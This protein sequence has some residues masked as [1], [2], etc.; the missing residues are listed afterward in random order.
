LS[1]QPESRKFAE[2]GASGDALDAFPVGWLTKPSSGAV[3][4]LQS[5]D[6]QHEH[7]ALNRRNMAKIDTKTHI[8]DTARHLFNEHG[9]GATTTAALAQ[10]TGKTEGNIWYH[11]KTK[12]ALLKAITAQF[13]ERSYA[14]IAL[15]PTYG[16]NIIL[17]Y[18]QMLH[19]FAGELRDFRFLYRDQLEYGSPTDILGPELADF[20][21]KTL[22]QFQVYFRVMMDQGILADEPERI[23]T[24]ME[25][26]IVIIR[27]HLEMWRERGRESKPGSRA[28]EQ[29]F[30]LHVKL[31]EPLMKPDA[32]QVLCAAIANREKAVAV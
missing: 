32:V 18:A 7:G 21:E 12:D 28:V 26:S 16:G 30:A 14:R 20:Y 25:A 27:F 22:D 9:F 23:H 2:K 31:L 13:V 4:P 29:A 15:R 11:F 19:V 3:E 5:Q 1:R 8:L 17:E 10:A 24:L 6:A